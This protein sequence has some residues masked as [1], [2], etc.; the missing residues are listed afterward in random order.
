MKELLDPI[1]VARLDRG[2]ELEHDVGIFGHPPILPIA[3]PL[4]HE[5]SWGQVLQY[6]ILLHCKT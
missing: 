6:D 3:G 1:P 2:G 4:P 5:P